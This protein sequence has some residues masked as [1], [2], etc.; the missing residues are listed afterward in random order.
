MSDFTVRK[1]KSEDFERITEIYGYYVENSGVTFEFEA[2]DLFEV[3][4]RMSEVM[5]T[6]ECLVCEVDG[7]V[8]GFAYAAAL[9]KRP[10][11][12][13]SCEVTI[14][15]DKDMRGRGIGR[16]LYERLLSDLKNMGITNAYACVGYTEEPDEYLSHASP[17]FHE[18]M[19]FE[20][21]GHFRGCGEKFGRI[22]DVLWMEKI[23]GQDPF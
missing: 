12:D 14:Y 9:R 1:A 11:Y 19:G 16:L 23:I 7:E 21:A 17:L 18:R 10:A 13:R 6:H 3:T 22:Y 15:I 20:K 5:K 8:K 2:P 4:R